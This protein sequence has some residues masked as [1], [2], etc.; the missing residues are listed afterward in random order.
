VK[1]RTSVISIFSFVR[2]SDKLGGPS[3]NFSFAL[4]FSESLALFIDEVVQSHKK[5]TKEENEDGQR[6]WEIDWMVHKEKG[7]IGVKGG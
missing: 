1:K 3:P 4:G 7:A 5:H 2:G 6:C